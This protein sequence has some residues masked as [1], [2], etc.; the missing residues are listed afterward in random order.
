MKTEISNPVYYS[1]DSELA[2]IGSILINPENY[3]E[4]SQLINHR[5]F[6]NADYRLIFNAFENL[7]ESGTDWDLFNVA[8]E[9]THKNPNTDWLKYLATISKN[10]LSTKTLSTHVKIISQYSQIR[11]W[12]FAYSTIKD[13]GGDTNYYPE[14]RLINIESFVT[15]LIT[16]KPTT[17]STGNY[18]KTYCR[19]FIDYVESCFKA[20]NGITGLDTGWQNIN[21]RIGG[22]K[23]GTLTLIAARPSMGKS[24]FGLNLANHIGNNLKKTVLFFTLEMTA[25]ELLARLSAQIGKIDLQII[26]N[27][28]F[29]EDQWSRLSF[30]IG[31]ISDSEIIIDQS[32]A[33]TISQIV[34][35]AHSIKRKHGLSLIIIDHIGLIDSTGENETVKLSKISRTLKILAKDLDLPVVALTQLNRSVEQRADKRPV[36]SDL[37]QS[38]SLEQDADNV[39]FIYWDGYYNSTTCYPEIIEL[40]WA[41]VR[42]GKIGTD[43]FNRDF[44]FCRFS[45]TEA[46]NDYGAEITPFAKKKFSSKKNYR[47]DLQ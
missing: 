1:T 7:T 34:S 35:I 31:K 13:L 46:P 18:A 15:N 40:I 20:P 3:F 23:A 9:L 4:V 11:K 24:N 38:G 45:E 10:T 14:E 27:A 2:V 29:D 36:L 6:Y 30:S 41:K 17:G 22:L 33:L 39:G 19:E 42:G 8:D 28:S 43:F 5:D 21:D 37:R 16:S 26:N 44:K 32:P 47:D 25:T 12:V